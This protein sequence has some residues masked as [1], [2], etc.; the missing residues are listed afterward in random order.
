MYVFAAF[1]AELNH[2]RM[3]T[4]FA[5]SRI[6]KHV[7][8]EI[9]EGRSPQSGWLNMINAASDLGSTRHAA[10]AVPLVAYGNDHPII[11]AES[12]RISIQKWRRGYNKNAKD[13]KEVA[14]LMSWE[15]CDQFV[16]K[17]EEKARRVLPVEYPD[18]S[19]EELD[20]SV[21]DCAN[22]AR[23]LFAISRVMTAIYVDMKIHLG[24]SLEE[25]ADYFRPYGDWY[26]EHLSAL[27]DAA[28]A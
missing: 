17:L 26:D 11:G 8:P 21:M 24:L 2:A 27:E 15:Y 14:A 18:A 3:P 25:I 16:T 4:G 13:K 7:L 5:H 6:S 9:E 12:L 23:A 20:D 22:T 10:R 1:E 19:R 28:G